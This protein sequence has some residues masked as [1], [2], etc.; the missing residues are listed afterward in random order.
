MSYF[1]TELSEAYAW[2]AVNWDKW[3]NL[4]TQLTDGLGFVFD[5]TSGPA[6]PHKEPHWQWCR[7]NRT[8]LLELYNELKD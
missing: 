2:F 4:N 1:D 6:G 3:R 7:D 8:A 5:N